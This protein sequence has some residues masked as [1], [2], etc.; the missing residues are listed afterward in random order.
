MKFW[1]KLG[2]GV[3]LCAVWLATMLPVSEAKG[4]ADRV[5]IRGDVLTSEIVIEERNILEL[6]A[7]GRLEAFRTPLDGAP[8]DIANGFEIERQYRDG[9]GSE[10]YRTFDRVMYYPSTEQGRGYI[11]YLG[12]ENGASGWDGDWFYV[13][14][15]AEATLQQILGEHG[16]LTTEQPYVIRLRNPLTGQ[17]I[18]IIDL[19]N[20][21]WFWQI[22]PLAG[23]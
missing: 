11:H 1:L 21:R 13:R 4:P 14:P 16:A 5:I 3:L 17:T 8:T 23:H 22:S 12:L 2:A 7:M 18:A 9:P 15:E 20:R 19:Q 10:T 6:L